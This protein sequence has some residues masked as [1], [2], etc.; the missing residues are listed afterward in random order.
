MHISH[1]LLYQN[2]ART[3]FLAQIKKLKTYRM[4]VSYSHLQF[5]WEIQF[6]HIMRSYKNHLEIHFP[7]GNSCTYC[8]SRARMVTECASF[9]QLKERW[10]L[11]Y[12][13]SEVNQHSLKVNVSACILLHNMCIGKWDRFSAKLDMSYCTTKTTIQENLRK[14]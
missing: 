2:I 7:L 6:F 10:R 1:F 14:N 9:G 11:F 13:K 8:L 12:R 4:E 5:W 3:D